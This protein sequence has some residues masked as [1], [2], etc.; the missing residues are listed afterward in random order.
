MQLAFLDGS[1]KFVYLAL[2]SQARW[3]ES[4]EE[5]DGF[6]DAIIRRDAF[7][8]GELM[9]AHVL[10]TGRVVRDTLHPPDIDQRT[11]ALSVSA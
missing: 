3:D 9:H 2:F 11:D 5:H 8:A 10:Q 7:T 1:F 6:M 4:M